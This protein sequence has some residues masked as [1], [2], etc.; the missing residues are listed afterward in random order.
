MGNAQLF[1]IWVMSDHGEAATLAT[2]GVGP[3]A[4]LGTLPGVC[5]AGGTSDRPCSLLRWIIPVAVPRRDPVDFPFTADGWAQPLA[6]CWLTTFLGRG[7]LLSELP[8]PFPHLTFCLS[9]LLARGAFLSCRQRLWSPTSQA[10][11]QV[12]S[13]SESLTIPD[14]HGCLPTRQGFS[15]CG[16]FASSLWC[17]LVH[18][19][20]VFWE[21]VTCVCQ[22]RKPR[23]S[24]FW[25]TAP[26]HHHRCSGFRGKRMS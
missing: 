11:S 8:H 2:G 18:F 22:R 21:D 5:S 1:A 7:G 12:T 14:R 17:L 9:Y 15:S 24:H 20:H 4:D 6:A 3:K 26:G 10:E 16:Y 25:S 19:I 23:L 13:W